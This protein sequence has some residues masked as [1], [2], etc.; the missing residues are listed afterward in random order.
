MK[1]LVTGTEGYL[2]CLLA[3][4]L[5]R[6]GHEVLG[7]DTGYYKSGWLYQG[8]DQSP[9]TLQKDLRHVTI[10]DMAGMD[11]IVHL[12]ELSNDPVGQLAPHIT[13]DVNHKGSVRLA[14]LAR[15]AGIRRFVYMSSCSVYGVATEPIVSETSAINPQTAYAECKVLVER[16]LQAMV[17]ETFVPTF[18]RNATAFGASPRQ[19]FD[20]VLNNLMG[21]AWTTKRIAMTS[22]GTPWR[23]LVHALD[24]S[25]AITSVLGAPE[26]V[27]RGQVFN[28][29][30]NEQN[31]QIKEVAEI[32]AE[33]V[34]GCELSFGDGQDNRSYRVNFDKI[35][36]TLPDF[37]CEWDAR[38][39][40]R[41][42]ADV[43]TKIGFDAEMFTARGFTRL[44]QIEH[45]I[46]T[47]QLDA[48]FFWSAPTS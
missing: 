7:V 18:M 41:Q 25:R 2:G 8:L 19:R 27:V 22:D 45:L 14:N 6:D 28:V 13:F 43:F 20:L 47:G 35:H 36:T 26:D 38:R 39:G 1:I 29:G 23:P 21:L 30:S 16:D 11:A 9:K 32:V 46:A 44:K 15:E 5:M 34:P 31:Y 4:V 37:R 42:L 48:D 3:G 10:D 33:T 12:A 17:S 40:A 24:I